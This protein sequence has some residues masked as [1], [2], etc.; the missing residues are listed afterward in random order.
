MCLQSVLRTIE[1]DRTPSYR[2]APW[3]CVLDEQLATLLLIHRLSDERGRRA[4]R[5]SL[6][7]QHV[8]RLLAYAQRMTELALRKR[9]PD[10]LFDAV[11]ALLV[12]D[13]ETDGR[14]T[15]GLL[16]DVVLACGELGIGAGELL[17]RATRFASP[18]AAELIDAFARA[19]R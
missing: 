1:R 13:L 11:L 15:A 4:L 18:R 19:G 17:A 14:R 2:A 8:A 9:A 10:R 16:H 3:P 6:G 7:P 5:A 12:E